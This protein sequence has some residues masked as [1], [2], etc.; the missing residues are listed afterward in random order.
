MMFTDDEALALSVGLLAASRLGLQHAAAAVASARAKLERVL[1]PRLKRRVKAV[2]GTITLDLRQRSGR[3]QDAVLAALTSAA[4]TQTRVRL[5]YRA[6]ERAETEREF[7]AYGLVY[8]EGRWYAA[9][10][11]HLRRGLRTF[12]LDRVLSVLPL[13]VGFARPEGFD[14]LSHVLHSVATL[15]RRFHAEVLLETDLSTARREVS[16]VLG[17]LEIVPEGVLLRVEVDDLGWLAKELARLPFDLTIRRPAALNRALKGWAAHL[18][19]VSSRR[20]ARLDNARGASRIARP[21]SIG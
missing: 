4:E 20:P 11:C 17:V 5:R 13:A 19:A 1:P 2:D 15:P 14:A 21:C 9:G 10:M 18:L 7:D 16:V 6:G 3:A 12:R 8:R